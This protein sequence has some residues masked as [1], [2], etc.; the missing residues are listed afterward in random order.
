MSFVTDADKLTAWL[1]EHVGGK[2]R[3]PEQVRVELLARC[4]TES[5]E[6]PTP[7]RCDRIVGAALRVAEETLTA[8]IS[9]RLTVE[10][11]ERIVALVAGADQEDDGVPGEAGV[12][13]GEDGPPVLGKI[14]GAPGNLSLETMLA[15]IDKLLAVRAVGLPPD[16]FA[17]VAPKVVAG[18]R[19]RAAVRSPPGRPV[20][21]LTG[22]GG[23]AAVPSRVSAAPAGV[24]SS[25]AR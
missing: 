9:A 4:R 14:K 18:W 25:A 2:E 21:R 8:R 13:E 3:R 5:I 22:T 10:S 7:G 15:E 12:G 19:A 16:L 24:P 6:P 11:T 23:R 17:D 20:G 1:A